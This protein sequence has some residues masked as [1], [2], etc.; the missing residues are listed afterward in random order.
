MAWSPSF[1]RCMVPGRGVEPLRIAI[2]KAP[3][4][5]CLPASLP[6]ATDAALPPAGPAPSSLEERE[7]LYHHLAYSPEKGESDEAPGENQA[8]HWRWAPLLKH[9]APP[10]S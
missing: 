6:I 10:S 3:A 1:S 7:R 9:C 4:S 2:G 5:L 8:N